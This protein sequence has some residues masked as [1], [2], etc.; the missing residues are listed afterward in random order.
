MSK[1]VGLI[2]ITVLLLCDRGRAGTA[3][4]PKGIW[5]A[6]F[7]TGVITEITNKYS[8]DGQLSSIGRLNQDFDSAKIAQ[9]IPEFADLVRI[10]DEEVSGHYDIGSAIRVGTLEFDANP[11]VNY[12]APILGYGITD[13]WTLAVGVP[14]V[15]VVADP[16]IVQGK[17]NN[18]REVREL[19]SDR[20]GELSPRADDAFDQL[21]TTSLVSAFHQYMSDKGYDPI[22]ARD[23]TVVG[24]LQVLSLHELYSDQHWAVVHEINLNLPTGEKDDPNDFLDV[25]LFGQTSIKFAMNQD[26]RL[27]AKW[28]LTSQVGYKWRFADKIDK[29]VPEHK[30][31]FLPGPER[32]ETVTRRLGDEVNL[33]LGSN[34][35]V[36]RYINLGVN[37]MLTHKWRDKYSGNR[38]YD[39][40]L[41][42]RESDK[43]SHV[44][45]GT[46]WFSTV[47]SFLAKEFSV[48]LMVGYAYSD[49]V[50]GSNIERA[51][52]HEIRFHSFF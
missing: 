10:L 27:T 40:S 45:Q 14:I 16:V 19:M 29:R 11:S 36:T 26:Y 37:Y 34:Y 28:N 1:H 25:P 38:G 52:W 21:E 48:P 22:S 44:V 7:R 51:L 13:K 39:Y 24:D 46:A 15:N 47:H 30:E 9:Y 8:A 31:D 2:F 32:T 50:A 43:Y 3:V 4:L 5:T 41:L 18:A 20:M 42:S 23:Y 6:S 49:V 17:K 33:H 35:Q 12:F